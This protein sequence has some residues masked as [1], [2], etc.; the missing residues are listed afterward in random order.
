[1]SADLR[2]AGNVV[3]DD[4]RYSLKEFIASVQNVISLTFNSFIMIQVERLF[5][6]TGPPAYTPLFQWVR[7]GLEA[8]GPMRKYDFLPVE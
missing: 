2:L 8:R 7:L 1:M 3:D 4:V 6:C 5:E